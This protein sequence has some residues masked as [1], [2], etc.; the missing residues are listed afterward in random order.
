MDINTV[1]GGILRV[2]TNSQ[3]REV[4]SLREPRAS[5]WNPIGSR[6]LIILELKT[7]LTRYHY[8]DWESN[9]P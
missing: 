2:L 1:F 9:L 7:N 5:Y 4:S 6:G 8:R 3:S